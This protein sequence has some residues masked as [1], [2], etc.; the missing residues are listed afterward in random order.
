MNKEKEV[1]TETTQ[2]PRTPRELLQHLNDVEML[3][4]T[5]DD[6]WSRH[7]C[8]VIRDMQNRYKTL[9]KEYTEVNNELQNTAINKDKLRKSLCSSQET[10]D[11]LTSMVAELENAESYRMIEI[12][13]LRRAM[14]KL[15]KEKR[16]IKSGDDM[17]RRMQE[18]E[19]R[20]DSWDEWFN[21][22]SEE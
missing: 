14:K 20:V 19:K 6:V 8:G 10:V 15:K 13:E 5:V 21:L 9:F 1:M 7:A 18:L 4:H 11:N 2:Y 22:D 12:E 17:R 3:R 16:K